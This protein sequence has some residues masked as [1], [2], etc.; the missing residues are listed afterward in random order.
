MSFWNCSEGGRLTRL[1]AAGGREGSAEEKR[2]VEH[3]AVSETHALR[4]TI[5]PM[6]PDQRD[7]EPFQQAWSVSVGRVSSRAVAIL[8]TEAAGRRE[9]T[10][11]GE[12]S[13][14]RL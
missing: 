1:F 6:R 4:R 5:R 3:K 14:R 10:N 7:S 11:I 13:S 12:V 8:L 9:M 2:R